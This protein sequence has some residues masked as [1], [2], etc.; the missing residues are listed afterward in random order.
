MTINP[1]PFKKCRNC[2]AANFWIRSINR[3][4][5]KNDPFEDDVFETDSYLKAASH[6]DQI[7]TCKPE[8]DSGIQNEFPPYSYKP[9]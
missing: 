8:N 9:G 4:P 5:L 3:A 2:A 1:Q 7:K 6:Q